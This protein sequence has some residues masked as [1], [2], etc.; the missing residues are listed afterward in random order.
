M[1]EQI[2][3]PEEVQLSDKEIA[4]LSDAEFKAPAIRKLRESQ[5]SCTH[6]S[7][8]QGTSSLHYPRLKIR[9]Q[10]LTHKKWPKRKNRSKFQKKYN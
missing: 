2:E 7:T 4:K 6:G 9:T 3:A 1:K 8:N 10:V 5:R